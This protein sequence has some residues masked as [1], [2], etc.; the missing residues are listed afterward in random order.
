[1]GLG[2]SGA[3]H[4]LVED[5]AGA[6]TRG[7]AVLSSGD[8]ELRAGVAAASKL[9]CGEHARRENEAD[10]I[11]PAYAGRKSRAGRT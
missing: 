8:E 10:V 2:R 7:A 3:R 9:A 6:C 11:A 4:G 5:E 1:M